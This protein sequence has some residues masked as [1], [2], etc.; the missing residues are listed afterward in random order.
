[1]VRAREAVDSPPK[2]SAPEPTPVASTVPAAKA[3][4][5][6]TAGSPDDLRPKAGRDSSDAAESRVFEHNRTGSDSPF[7][8]PVTLRPPGGTSEWQ[9][10][11]ALPAPPGRDVDARTEH[12]SPPADVGLTVREQI[13]PMGGTFESASGAVGAGALV[14]NPFARVGRPVLREVAPASET[15]GPVLQVRG[16]VEYV[17]GADPV[18]AVAVPPLPPPPSP[19]APDNSLIRIPVLETDLDRI[20]I[21]GSNDRISLT[22]R[23]APLSAVV[24]L[25]AQ[26]HKLNV[27]A[28]DDMIGN[29][30]VTL[31]DVRLEDALNAIL[32]VNGYTW[33]RQQNIILISRV[34][35][36]RRVAPAIQGRQTR[37][38]ELNYVS[39]TDLDKVVKGLLSPSGQS[40]VTDSDPLDKRR[41]R[42]RIVVEDLPEYVER[43][44]TYIL[45]V[46][47]PPRQVLI[48]ARVY[49]VTLRDNC[50]AGVDF[51]ALFRLAGA[52]IGLRSQGFSDSPL[53]SPAFFITVDGTD[54][55]VLAS[56]LEDTTDAKTLANSKLLV[57]NAQE[58]RIQIGEQLGY[59]VTT[60]TQTSTL[61]N[62][63]FIDVGVVLRVTPIIGD[64][65][66]VLMSV[67]PEVS[68]GRINPVTGL[69]EEATT[70]VES[71]ILL[72][73][74]CGMVIGGLIKETDSDFQTKV[75]IIGDLWMVGR[76]F[77][78][79]EVIRERTEIII[80]LIP[81]ILPYPP[82]V[83]H[84]ENV[85]VL[86][87]GTPLFVGALDNT[88]RLGLEPQLP[89][90][91][92]NPLRLHG[93]RLED[94]IFG[95]FDEYPR[96][97]SYYFPCPGEA[98]ALPPIGPP[99]EIQYLPI[100]PE[101]PPTE[102]PRAI[103]LPGPVSESGIP[104]GW[105]PAPELP[106]PAPAAEPLPGSG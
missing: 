23:D 88:H 51:D 64:D 55:D 33:V 7:G 78:S 85:D 63:D 37:V 103:H 65:N 57:V 75:P 25:I 94:G 86:R 44:A 8:R 81:H 52:E 104:P 12:A 99:A 10:G 34:G 96:P 79:R 61:Q 45:Q 54:L 5:D 95:T 77:Q 70:E 3:P 18:P 83:E 9:T 38:F 100:H 24:G 87:A 14:E 69:P 21:A 101:L 48:E 66:Q 11:P 43:I 50:R 1:M 15:A 91:I 31:S 72:P 97:P 73:S 41:T 29:I 22:V 19:Q 71:T 13:V 46:D 56:L 90:A 26:Q 53:T 82:E 27:V 60:T 40:F 67:K 49:Q 39:A 4:A 35:G 16:D 106:P 17:A 59:L 32:A 6:V 93:G 92:H 102:S 20:E 76:L 28:S 62:V 84:R 47:R 68:S 58:A 105:P 74:G 89:D 36:E 80:T 30:T 42:E 2:R 98:A